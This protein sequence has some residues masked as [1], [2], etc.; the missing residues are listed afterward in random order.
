MLAVRFREVRH[1]VAAKRM[2][3]DITSNETI[4]VVDHGGEPICELFA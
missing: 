2:C 4:R 1:M 3:G